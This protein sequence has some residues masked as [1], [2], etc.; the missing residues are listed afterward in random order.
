MLQKIMEMYLFPTF[1]QCAI[2]S[3]VF[4]LWILRTRLDT[5][6]LL[7]NFINDQ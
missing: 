2:T 1:V 6:A 7:V 4:D 5:F 3:I